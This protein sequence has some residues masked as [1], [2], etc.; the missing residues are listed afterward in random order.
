M[1]TT[2]DGTTE[3]RHDGLDITLRITRVTARMLGQYE[4]AYRV[5]RA[6]PDISVVTSG[7]SRMKADASDKTADVNTRLLLEAVSGALTGIVMQERSNEARL[8][9]LRAA[10]R[11][12][13]ILSPSLTDAIL[14]D[15][16]PAQAL[17]MGD[18]IRMLYAELTTIDPN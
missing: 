3:Y 18:K 16:P 5:F 4:A 6:E 10:H 8:L 11:A 17:W 15:L 14:E 7:L 1:S 9:A 2:A 12:G 13:W